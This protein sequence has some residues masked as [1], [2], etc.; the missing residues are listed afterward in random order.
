MS[1]IKK[2]TNHV[3]IRAFLFDD[4]ELYDRISDDH[5]AELMPNKE[6]FDPSSSI[7]VGY[8]EGDICKAL[9]SATPETTIALNIHINV[10]K[11][12]RPGK[13][14][15]MCE[16]II[17]YIEENVDRRYIK[18]SAT[19]PIIYKDVSKFMLKLGFSVWGIEKESFL[20][21][22]SLIDRVHFSREIEV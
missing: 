18:L 1:Q 10:P 8:F 13:S 17:K 7:W 15:K 14:L 6:R 5:T 20:K 16:E 22:G 12:Y 9:I 11:K 3:F 2:V 4:P 21:N 19:V